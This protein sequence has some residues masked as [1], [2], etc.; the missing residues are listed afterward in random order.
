[1]IKITSVEVP[2]GLYSDEVKLSELSEV[3]NRLGKQKILYITCSESGAFGPDTYT[4]STKK[5]D[6]TVWQYLHLFYD[7]ETR[8]KPRGK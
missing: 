2:S 5:T 6:F 8:R 1:M 3:V 7:E 4:I